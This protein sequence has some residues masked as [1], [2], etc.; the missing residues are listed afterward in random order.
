MRKAVIFFVLC[1]PSATGSEP[2]SP[3]GNVVNFSRKLPSSARSGRGRLA[4]VSQL[5]E[6]THDGRIRR[7]FWP[8]TRTTWYSSSS[9]SPP[10]LPILYCFQNCYKELAAP[11]CTLQFTEY[12]ASQ[13][14]SRMQALFFSLLR[15]CQQPSLLAATHSTCTS[16]N[17][18]SN[19]ILDPEA[20]CQSSHLRTD[21]GYK[22]EFCVGGGF[23]A[24]CK[25]YPTVVRDP[26]FKSIC[27]NIVI[28]YLVES[29]RKADA[30]RL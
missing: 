17:R 21:T 7:R 20:F 15:T 26:T 28:P 1:V 3:M 22:K 29:T 12:E 10:L 14:C 16:F 2:T 9:F 8:S 30:V 5:T 24:Y 6:A 25:K 11:L 23:S 27:R 18:T 13:N 19:T 4:S